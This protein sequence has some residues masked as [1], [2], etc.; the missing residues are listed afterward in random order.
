MKRNS[1]N[2]NYM[3]G[4]IA[5]LG[6]LV[7]AIIPQASA[8]T[9]QTIVIPSI[10]G[11]GNDVVLTYEGQTAQDTHTVLLTRVHE[12][13]AN[14]PHTL[15]T[16]DSDAAGTYDDCSDKIDLSASVP[17]NDPPQWEAR[18][19]DGPDA[20]EPFQIF[21]LD[22][23]DTVSFAFGKG[24]PSVP[25]ITSGAVTVSANKIVWVDIFPVTPTADNLDLEGEY[26]WESCGTESNGAGNWETT[27]SIIVVI[28]ISGEILP[29]ST[30]ALILAGVSTSAIWLVPVIGAFAGIGLTLYKVRRHN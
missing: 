12:P 11:I 1:T 25:V 20:G 26:K 10:V 22:M 13:T 24:L 27:Q 3:I 18:N 29:I 5:L 19:F 9:A 23:C 30:T 21:D 6:I 4:A 2:S 14:S 15:I 28:P 7:F 16:G 17:N 8:M